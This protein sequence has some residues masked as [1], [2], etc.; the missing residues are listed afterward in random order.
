MAIGNTVLG[1]PIVPTP[2]T[3]S[4]D[5]YDDNR[6]PQVLKQVVDLINTKNIPG[7]IGGTGRTGPAPTGAG[8]SSTGPTGPRGGSPTG[9]SFFG[10]GPTG[11][12][13]PQGPSG[14]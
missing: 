2:T 11:V 13:G 6:I 5:T 9:P 14:P 4:K 3:A 7:P 1:V 10:A 12:T 8:G